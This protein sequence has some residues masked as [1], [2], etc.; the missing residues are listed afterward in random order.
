[1]QQR[2]VVLIT[3]LVFLASLSL[4]ALIATSGM[5]LQRHQ[6]ANFQDR[7]RA[8][9]IAGGAEYLALS[10]LFSRP[11]NSRE[12]H[13]EQNC[14]LPENVLDA[15]SLPPTPEF[16]AK[17]WWRNHGQTENA[18]LSFWL[19]EEI[20]FEPYRP[21][22]GQPLF[23][24]VGY[25]RILSRGEGRRAGNISV[26]EAIAARPWEGDF[27]PGQ[28]SGTNRKLDFCSQFPEQ[29]PCGILTWRQRR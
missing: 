2:G 7:T 6:A 10:W 11:N 15:G 20:H 18:G 21:A 14:V 25:Y 8:L 23:A 28:P 19:I 1:M 4:L 17:S 13:C 9:S 26:T 27:E 22:F 5:T 24:G 3:G 12:A 29:V 16:E